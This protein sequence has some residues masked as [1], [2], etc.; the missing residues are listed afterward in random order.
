MTVR[1]KF[2]GPLANNMERPIIEVDAE[3]EMRLGGILLR[4]IELHQQVREHWSE[5]GDI[6]REALVLLNGVDSALL[7]GLDA[8]VRD[9]DMIEI[10]P[11]VHGG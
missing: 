3:D 11:L 8:T 9:D 4:A 5:P 1:V 10:L 2:R 7:G 6:E